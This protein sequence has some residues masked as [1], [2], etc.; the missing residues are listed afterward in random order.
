MNP[1]LLAA[2][3]RERQ[4]EAVRRPNPRRIAP[5]IGVVSAS[6][7][8]CAPRRCPLTARFRFGERA[9][10]CGDRPEPG[11]AGTVPPDAIAVG[12]PGV[13]LLRRCETGRERLVL[14]PLPPEAGPA[15]RFLREAA[16]AAVLVR[17]GIGVS[18]PQ[19]SASDH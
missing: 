2:L 8:G 12:E 19:A 7:A 17:M 5:G 13:L 1:F 9:S 15:D 18:G 6:R 3:A 14:V 16:V 11:R 4:R 10:G